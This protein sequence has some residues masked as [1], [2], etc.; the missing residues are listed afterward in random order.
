MQ[1][2]VWKARSRFNLLRRVR[3]LPALLH[4]LL[5]RLL[6]QLRPHRSPLQRR[7]FREIQLLRPPDFRTRRSCQSRRIRT[8]ALRC[9][10]RR[11]SSMWLSLRLTRRGGLS[12]DLKPED[13]EVY[14]NGQKRT[15]RFFN[16]AGAQAEPV[17]SAPPASQATQSEPA[18]FTNRSASTG[19]TLASANA[20]TTV[21]LIDAANVAFSDLTYAR[22]E[23]LRFLKT[24]APDERVGLLHLAEPRL[25]DLAGA[26]SR[27]PTGGHGPHAF[28]Y[29]ARRTLLGL[30]TR[31]SATGSSSTGCTTRP[32][33]RM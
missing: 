17:Q 29:P 18:S 19:P 22:S 25:S 5:Q 28:D 31:N 3:I 11:V 14:D 23:M 2:P 4:F 1:S 33:W 13:L 32:T 7:Q 21:L 10:P 24:L 27:S 26:H 8:R 20:D 15:I 30:K 12:Q 16:Q 6:R 9:G